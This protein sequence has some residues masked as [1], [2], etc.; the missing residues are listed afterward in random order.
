MKKNL[1]LTAVAVCLLFLSLA[2]ANAQTLVASWEAEDF[3]GMG[4]YTNAITSTTDPSI[5]GGAYLRKGSISQSNSLFYYVNVAEAGWYDLTAYYMTRVTDATEVG[6]GYVCIGVRINNQDANGIMIESADATAT[7]NSNPGSKSVSVYLEEGLNTIRI[8][9]NKAFRRKVS[10]NNSTDGRYL[11][12]IDRFELYRDLTKTDP[13]PGDVVN[14]PE[15]NA[16]EQ[17]AADFLTTDIDP[18]AA[19]GA[20]YTMINGIFSIECITSPDNTTVNNLI[21]HNPATTFVSEKDEETFIVTYPSAT[22]IFCL[23][24]IEALNPY[25]SIGIIERSKDNVDWNSGFGRASIFGT[26]DNISNSTI[27]I[28]SRTDEP[29]PTSKHKDYIYYRFT[30]KKLPGFEGPITI[31]DLRICGSFQ[32]YEDLTN[33]TN[34]SVSVEAIGTTGG[35]FESNHLV[36]A[37]DNNFSSKCSYINGTNGVLMNVTYTF[38]EYAKVNY[39]SVTTAGGVN[40]TLQRDPVSWRL[41]GW[42][43]GVDPVVLDEVTDHAWANVKRAQVLRK[44]DVPNIYKYYKLYLTKKATENSNGVHIGEFQLIGTLES[45]LLSGTQNPENKS[46]IS[47]YASEKSIVINN[48][49]NQV[50]SYQ[51]FD[52]TGKKVKSGIAGPSQN[53]IFMNNG[54]YI[55]RTNAGDVSNSSKVLIH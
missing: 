19:E 51:I 16:Y 44:I 15:G 14:N 21:D 7:D 25:V 2:G 12:P 6:N 13:A 49:A 31:P 54:L 26:S 34:G 35:S 24:A 42:N 10:G 40:N 32:D 47:V 3:I 43:V 29:D 20:D 48:P 55:V 22:G 23:R 38:N 46:I 30:I 8:G 27:G 39:Y 50:V 37:I 17:I 9:Q 28:W 36:N 45:S 5:S 18:F 33:T 1:Q 41:E 52:I 53:Q 4:F 11:P